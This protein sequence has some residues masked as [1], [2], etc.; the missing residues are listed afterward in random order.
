VATLIAFTLI[1]ML[2]VISILA[3]LAALLLPALVA[4]KGRA[5]LTKC[6]SNLRQIGLALRMYVNDFEKYPFFRVDGS[7]KFQWW[8]Q[9]L[10]AYTSMNWSNAL[11][12]CPA[13]PF[14]PSIANNAALGSY[15]Y[16]AFGTEGLPKWPSTGM[17]LGLG[18]FSVP[19]S[20]F[21]QPAPAILE[22]MVRV[23]S[24]MIAISDMIATVPMLGSTT[25]IVQSVS[26]GSWRKSWHRGIENTV[27]C[28]D[29]VETQKSEK[30]YERREAARRRFNNDNEPHPETW[31]D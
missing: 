20:S 14:E 4:V 11:F 2:V 19:L 13:N 22:S 7:S 10:D 16:N 8:F 27:F 1:E 24:E 29:H 17:Q 9:S 26:Y 31:R 28:E 15:G 6:C 12:R 23:P 18:P 25:N 21:A 3:I 5:G 30:L